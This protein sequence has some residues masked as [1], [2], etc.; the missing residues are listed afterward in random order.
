MN[1][2]VL[3]Q[4]I[5]QLEAFNRAK[6]LSGESSLMEVTQA[7]STIKRLVE[8]NSLPIEKDLAVGAKVRV[9]GQEYF[10]TAISPNTK[11]VSLTLAKRD[12]SMPKRTIYCPKVG[13]FTSVLEIEEVI[14]PQYT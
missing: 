5:A 1:I 9:K 2:K 3:K 14:K 11:E 4:A 12:G 6:V 8:L 7:I 10:I 13:Y